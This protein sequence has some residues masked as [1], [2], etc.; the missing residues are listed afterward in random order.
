MRKLASTKSRFRG[1]PGT[2]EILKLVVR[3]G[4]QGEGK[5]PPRGKEVREKGRKE[6]K[7]E[8]KK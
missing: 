8:R 6:R 2:K 3:K 7:D 4:V 5:P 1:R